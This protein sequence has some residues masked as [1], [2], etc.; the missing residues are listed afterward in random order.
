[1]TSGV[2]CSIFAAEPAND[3]RGGM[4]MQ[5]T[6]EVVCLQMTPGVVC[7]QGWFAVSRGGLQ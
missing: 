5:M 2:I 7:S 4:H 1:M 6:P 3:P